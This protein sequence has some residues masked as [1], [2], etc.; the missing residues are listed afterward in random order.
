M[1]ESWL[2]QKFARAVPGSNL[3]EAVEKNSYYYHQIQVDS[4]NIE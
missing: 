2:L 4:Q 3:G 1:V